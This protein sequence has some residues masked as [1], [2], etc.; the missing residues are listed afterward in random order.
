MADAHEVCRKGV[1][2]KAT[3]KLD[4]IKGHGPL[5]TAVSIVFVAEGDLAFLKG[6]KALIGDGNAVGV[7]GQVFENMLGRSKGWL[8]VDDP[9]G[10]I[11]AG[12]KRPPGGLLAEVGELAVKEYLSLFPGVFKIAKKLLFKERA[13]NAYRQKKAFAARYPAVTLRGYPATRNQNMHMGVVLKGLAPGM[14]NGQKADL[15]A[16]M[17]GVAADRLKGLGGGPKE[18]AVK[19][20]FVLQCDRCQGLRKSEDDMKVWDS[21]EKF[22]FPGVKPLCPGCG[23]TLRA[24]AVAARME[25]HF[26]VPAG[27][28]PFDLAPEHRGSARR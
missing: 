1:K 20:A 3:D 12:D 5:T 7:A 9:I 16:Q 22:F 4:R 18:N 25:K 26:G 23:L 14:K 15:G 19:D 28:A 13:E 10:F 11:L 6:Q 8:C 27:I 21:D 2:E 24:M 17:G